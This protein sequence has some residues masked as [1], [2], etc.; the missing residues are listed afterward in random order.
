MNVSRS[1]TRRSARTAA[2]C[3]AVL[4]AVVAFGSG[5]T[6]AHALTGGYYAPVAS[7]ATPVSI[8]GPADVV[9]A[10][11]GEVFVSDS[12]GRR[13]VVLAAD[14]TFLRAFDGSD[15]PGAELVEPAGLALDPEARLVVADRAGDKVVV[16][17][18]S[19]ETVRVFGA[20]GTAPGALSGPRGIAVDATGAI[21]VAD[22]GNDRISTYTS[23]GSYLATF[24]SPG[25]VEGFVRRPLSLSI[26]NGELYGAEES[27]PRRV[28]VFGLDGATHRLW[29]PFQ[30]GTFGIVSRYVGF[31]GVEAQLSGRTLVS[32]RLRIDA[33]ITVSGVESLTPAGDF[34]LLRGDTSV[35]G[36]TVGGLATD[37][38]DVALVA[39]TDNDRIARLNLAAAD[40]A[41]LAPW[42]H[43]GSSA[44]GAFLRPGAAAYAPNGDIYVADTA[45]NR[46]QRLSP[47][48]APLSVF[49]TSG[50]AAVSSPWG[51]AVSAD[52]SEV[53]VADT[54]N[55][56]IQVYDAVGGHLR[57]L[58]ALGLA[59]PRAVSVAPDGTLA[60]AD[61]GNDR[62]VRCTT[63]G[64]L[65]AT[66]A[67]GALDDPAGVAVDAA[68]TIY[69]SDTA[70]HRVRTFDAA[71][72]PTGSWGGFGTDPAEFVYPA[73][74]AVGPGGDVYVADTGN[75]RVQRLTSAGGFVTAIGVRG[76]G[77]SELRAPSGVCVSPSGLA[78]VAD[79][80]NSRIQVFELDT[81]APVTSQFGAT[82][83]WV[84]HPVSVR[85]SAV[86]ASSGVREIRYRL[87]TDAY[88]SYTGTFT[89]SAEG[90]TRIQYY[91][92]DRA[93][94][95]DTTRTAF[96]NIDMTPPAGTARLSGGAEFVAS[97]T[98]DLE[99]NVTDAVEMNIDTGSGWQGRVS[100]E[101]VK[102]LTLPGAGPRTV[103][104]QYIDVPGN[105]LTLETAVTVDLAAPHTDLL[106]APAS[107]I[108]SLPVEIS[109]VTGDDYSGVSD[110]LVTIDGA[111]EK[112]YAGAFTLSAEGVHTVS[113]RSIDAVGNAEDPV[114]AT[115]EIDTTPPSGTV[116]V[117]GGAAI[118]DGLTVAVVPSVAGASHMRFDTGDGSGY[119]DWRTYGAVPALTLPGEG[120]NTI[121]SQFVDAAGNTTEIV[122]H[123]TVDLTPPAT[124]VT[125]LPANA[126]T[127]FDVV[128]SL[129]A[130]DAYSAIREIRYSLD[131][132]PDAVYDGPITVTAEGPH[133]LSYFAIDAVGNTE[134]RSDVASFEID[135][136]VPDGTIALASGRVAADNTSPVLSLDLVN[137]AHVR[138]DLGGASGEWQPVTPEVTLD[139]AEEGL[140]SIDVGMRSLAG[141]E[142][143][144]TISVAV[145]LT[146]PR[147]GQVEVIP[148][149]LLT[150]PDDAWA[151]DLEFAWS[152]D[153]DGGPVNS[154]LSQFQWRFGVFG[155]F[156]TPAAVSI[157][158]QDYSSN[159]RLALTDGAGN[160]V[161]A[162]RPV[163]LWEGAE[164]EVP[165]AP[166]P[167]GSANTVWVPLDAGPARGDNFVLRCFRSEGDTY[168]LDRTVNATARAVMVG[169]VWRVSARPVLDA[170]DW[171]FVFQTN[172]ASAVTMG[173]PSATLTVA[174]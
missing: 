3:A 129:G 142:I 140:H 137:T 149:T 17:E 89:V 107:G 28:Q 9:V 120:P 57:T 71:G 172:G 35:L 94:N 167:A 31:G 78:L 108:T 139:L 97:T 170:G 147:L 76:A 106:G 21:Y 22:T 5:A 6:R 33:D 101:A 138:F 67:A 63:A 88:R 27:L 126:L 13:I 65:L 32:G 96:V 53:Y 112:P 43:E 174:R 29:G 128:V 125:G 93:G 86:D 119:G 145:D 144:R 152:A 58:G 121:R 171:R 61:T 44:A 148:A 110:T 12:L 14:G 166:R 113:A 154:G 75:S 84:N 123:V 45:N 49:A 42:S 150:K 40:P 159:L 66:T 68:G 100:Y 1:L 92:F 36:V 72:N 105:I 136:S 90:T 169:G 160:A 143:T 48:G 135:R 41:W 60:I 127:A 156:V 2:L 91:S 8:D 173:Q 39:D 109:L 70:Q 141:R 111:G 155:G 64:G 20:S 77:L 124:T 133:T 95:R 118:V 26:A 54:G 55:N 74:V 4:L 115:F 69:A 81:V 163:R 134:G 131:G 114:S 158:E 153:D 151:T 15:L 62:A 23:G 146:A 103:K 157:S 82:P 34:G 10:L 130:T 56:R 19:G 79:T 98:V 165:D 7:P 132:A 85:L 59:A 50:A 104:V 164:P 87:G 83:A 46:I 162:Q 16:F 52:G 38:S 80:G 161:T 30:Y 102:Q 168:V 99:S 25:D 73:G 24:A 116:E 11:N 47:S 51:I 37:A 122:S 117:A 18:R